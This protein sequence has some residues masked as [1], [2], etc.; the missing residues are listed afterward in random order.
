MME[1]KASLFVGSGYF[2]N[3]ST[4]IVKTMPLWGIAD[5]RRFDVKDS[6]SEL[7]T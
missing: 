2:G 7:S 5:V 3:L 1:L 6:S 4:W